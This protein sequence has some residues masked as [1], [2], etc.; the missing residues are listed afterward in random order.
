MKSIMTSVILLI[1]LITCSWTTTYAQTGSRHVKWHDGTTLTC[2]D[3]DELRKIV[4]FMINANEQ[5]ELY[6]IAE[7]QLAQQAIALIAKDSAILAKD[8][9]VAAKTSIVSL[10]EEIITGKD[11]EITD[12]RTALKKAGRKEKWLKIKWAGTSIILTGA[13][14]YVIIK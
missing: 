3:S 11:N 10:K 9:V 6:K 12:L 1:L 7:Q 14:L 5:A 2:Y 13:L 8:S 4:N